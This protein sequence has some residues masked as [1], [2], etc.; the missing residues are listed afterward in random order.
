M[1]KTITIETHTPLQIGYVFER[2]GK[3]YKVIDNNVVCKT[4]LQEIECEECDDD[5]E[6][7]EDVFDTDSGQYMRGVGSRKCICQSK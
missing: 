7:P 3:R 5:G 4:R 6:V 1:S 2:D